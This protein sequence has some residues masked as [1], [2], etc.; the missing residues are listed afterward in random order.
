MPPTFAGNVTD[1]PAWR[2]VPLRASLQVI[3][4]LPLS[5]VVTS[6][7]MTTASADEKGARTADEAPR[8]LVIVAL[9]IVVYW[10]ERSATVRAANVVLNCADKPLPIST[11]P[12]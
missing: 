9:L 1:A 8:I 5:S 2:A 11:Q 12:R 10:E 7:T 4:A 3:V 6:E